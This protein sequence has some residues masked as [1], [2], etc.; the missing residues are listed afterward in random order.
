MVGNPT[1]GNQRLQTIL[2]FSLCLVFSLYFPTLYHFRFADDNIYLSVENRLLHEAPWTELYKLL[3]EPANLWEFLPLRDF[4]YWLDFRL[5]GDEFA[6]FHLTNLI[7]YALSIGGA[8]AL[9][10]QLILFCRPDWEK[11]ASTLSLAGALLFA[12]HPAHVEAAAW[13]A[14]RKDLI[15]GSLSLF[16]LALLAHAMRYGCP[17]RKVLASALLFFLA[18]FGKSTTVAYVIFVGVLLYVGGPPREKSIGKNTEGHSRKFSGVFSRIF[19]KNDAGK[20]AT[21]VLFISLAVLASF[22][23]MR[24]GANTGVRIENHPGVFTMIERASR[25]LSALAGIIVCPYPMRFYYDVYQY[26]AWHW[27]ASGCVVASGLVA[28]HVLTKRRS[29]SALGVVLMF[30]PLLVYLQFIPFSTWSMASERFAFVSVAGLALI[31]IDVLARFTKLGT[32]GIFLAALVIPYSAVTWLRIGQWGSVGI[33]DLSDIEFEYQPNFSIVITTMISQRLVIAQRYGEARELARHLGRSY[34]VDSML[35]YIDAH[36]AYTPFR[37]LSVEDA[38]KPDF[39]AARVKFCAE[40]IKFRESIH[41]NSAQLR[42]EPDIT[43][44]IPMRTLETF[45]KGYENIISKKALC[46]PENGESQRKQ[47]NDRKSDQTLR[48]TYTIHA[49]VKIAMAS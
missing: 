7:W 29:L 30:S 21:I 38:T 23:H 20:F 44:Y 6:G 2:L 22:I 42:N 16:S 37:K 14:S 39:K 19:S 10:F 12:A 28:L 35:R 11:R 27:L 33:Y 13:V 46:N 8:Y 45:S 48:H 49:S 17:W 47:A 32:V 26:G 15:A 43:Y 41:K 5:F 1:Q 40:S 25:I 24:V 36:E 34:A 31:A 9:F 3:L 18:C 4:T